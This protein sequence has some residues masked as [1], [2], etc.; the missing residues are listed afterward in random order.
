MQEDPWNAI[1]SGAATGGI[2]AIRAGPK[3]A[4]RNAIAGGAILAAIEGLNL[5]LMRVLMPAF[6]QKQ[7]AEQGM[8]TVDTLLPPVDPAR[9]RNRVNRSNGGRS[10]AIFEAAPT[11]SSMFEGG[12]SIQFDSKASDFELQGFGKSVEIASTTADKPEEKK[13]GWLW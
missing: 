10:Q 2:L 8:S 3:A 4:A 12:N 6:E 7:A 11:T 1:I 5:V 9:A 13:K